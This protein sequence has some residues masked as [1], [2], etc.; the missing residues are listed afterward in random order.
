MVVSGIN[1][2]RILGDLLT[3]VTNQLPTEPPRNSGNTKHVNTRAQPWDLSK[4]L[5]VLEPVNL[6]FPRLRNTGI[7]MRLLIC[8]KKGWSSDIRETC[9]WNLGFEFWFFS[10]ALMQSS[11]TPCLTAPINYW[12]V[13]WLPFFIFPYIGNN[14]PNWLIFFRGAAQ[15]PTRL[16]W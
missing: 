13:V 1:L 5:D 4:F 16:A 10:A 6:E 12:L 9:A 3:R 7:A 14:H 15:P 8:C 11:P 2:L